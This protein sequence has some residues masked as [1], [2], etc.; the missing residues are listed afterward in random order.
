MWEPQLVHMA[1]VVD[2][3]FK[4]KLEFLLVFRQ[5]FEGYCFLGKKTG[6]VHQMG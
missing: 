2:S 5:F 4:L 6:L 1:K 3:V